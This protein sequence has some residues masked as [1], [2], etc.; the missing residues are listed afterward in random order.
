[1]FDFL[2][3]FSWLLLT[4]GVVG[5]VAV[6]L[7]FAP[8]AG[9]FPAVLGLMGTQVIIASAIVYG[10]RLHRQGKLGRRVLVYGGWALVVLL[11]IIGQ[12]WINAS[13][14]NL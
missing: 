9:S 4:F 2:R 1:M 12:I 7:G 11:L 13:E 8:R 6:A 14:I 3:I 10:F 5:F